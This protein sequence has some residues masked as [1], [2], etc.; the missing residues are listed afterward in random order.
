ML[1]YEGNFCNEWVIPVR[2]MS[3]LS[4]F[5]FASD[6]SMTVQG[7][8]AVLTGKLLYIQFFFVLETIRAKFIDT[9]FISS[10]IS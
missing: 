7:R 10:L 9:F 2:R 3:S 6:C 8:F 4:F 1:I 5:M